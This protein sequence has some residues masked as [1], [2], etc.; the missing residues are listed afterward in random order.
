MK[1][2]FLLLLAFCILF[3]CEKYKDKEESQVLD[4]RIEEAYPGMVG[5]LIYFVVN[6]DTLS[7]EKINEEYVY[8][9]DI[10][11]TI[12]QIT[13][14]L[15]LKASGA[16]WVKWWP[17][18]KVFYT[19]NDELQ[20]Q[21]R[22][23]DAIKDWE[24]NTTLEFVNRTNQ[25]NYIVFI[26]DLESCSSCLG[27]IGVRQVIRIA[28]WGTKGSVIHEIGHAVG[29]IH[30]QSRDDRNDYVIVNFNNIDPTKRHNFEIT[31]N[32][33]NTEGFDFN[34]IM[35]YPCYAFSI[36]DLPTITKLDGSTYKVNRNHLSL[37]DIDL[38][39]Q[40]YSLEIPLAAFNASPT[41]INVGQSVQFYDQSTNGPVSWLWYFGDGE[42]SREQ[43][44]LHTYS[45]TGTFTVK[46]QVSNGFGLSTTIK[47][48]Y[49]TV[50]PVGSAPI[51]AYIASPTTITVDKSIQFTDQ[52]TNNPTSW[53]WD[54][55]D[56]GTSTEQNPSHV[57][58]TVGTY[59]V[60]LTVKNSY[61]SDTETKPNYI[62]VT[63][64]SGE[65]STVTDYEGNVYNTIKIGNQWWMA[66][67]LTTIRYNDGTAIPLVTDN[68]AWAT[69]TT[70]AY[71]WY[72]NDEVTYKNTY[73]A[74]YNYYT[75]NIGNLCPTG[76][77]VP[78]DAEWT[79]LT[80]FLGGES[81]ASGK[82]KE[83]GTTHWL[84]PN[85][86]ATNESRFTAL[87]GGERDAV[88]F[89]SLGYVASFWTS[90]SAIASTAYFRFLLYDRINIYRDYFAQ[91]AGLSVRCVKD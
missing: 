33:I 40:V 41:N 11:L 18:K 88:S 57:Y 77:H 72:N 22:I 44:P 50:N 84:S 56:G 1:S 89:K 49:I 6:G 34:S 14:D 26:W 81:V 25:S 43:N 30:E 47:S 39:D 61:G 78:S 2:I 45:T 35:L 31:P 5:E 10:I 37:T 91:V 48:N 8:Q 38:I 65:T 87:P 82:L 85:A 59:T 76:W 80:T 64:S 62:T 68:S 32:S 52:S 54:F 9:G 73:G 53:D 74:L 70:P 60:S 83:T 23:T 13:H 46:L 20:N 75:V 7:C 29:L 12:D 90:T 55:G 51:A 58:S 67:N 17:D 3:A 71:C 42:I 66:E 19:I 69:L 36:N 4:Q 16:P 28:D 24:T 86:G 27:M 21:S 15:K 79:T 63:G